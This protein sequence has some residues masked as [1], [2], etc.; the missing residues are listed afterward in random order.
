MTKQPTCAERINDQLKGRLEDMEPECG[1]CVD[2][3]CDEHINQ[4]SV[5]WLN[6]QTVYRIQLSTG[7]PGDDFFVTI[8]DGGE[9]TRIEYQFLDWYDGARVEVT[10]DDFEL[11]KKWIEWQ[12]YIPEIH[13]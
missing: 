8:D 12:L 9:I 1:V 13:G 3:W 4:N 11:V 6:R 10:G 5:L 7:G 2:E